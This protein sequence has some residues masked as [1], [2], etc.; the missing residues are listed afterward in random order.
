MCNED[1]PLRAK[2]N[3]RSPFRENCLRS[4][5]VGRIRWRLEVTWLFTTG[6]MVVFHSHV[7]SG[8]YYWIMHGDDQL[9]RKRGEF[10]RSAEIK[11]GPACAWTTFFYE[12]GTIMKEL[13]SD[14]WPGPY[15][16][17]TNFI[18]HY[19]DIIAQ[20][21]Y[22]LIE[23]FS[24][25]SIRLQS[26]NI[27]YITLIPKKDCPVSANDYR[28]ISLL[29][30]SIKVITRLLENGLQKIILKLVHTNQYGF[31]SQGPFKTA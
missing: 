26:I 5:Y 16:F 4:Y 10:G 25:G 30:C 29:N 7:P 3:N 13:S 27:S 9:Q 23:D 31:L 28:P 12:V 21:L 15:V 2:R 11:F 20:D 1:C 18:K 8:R 24:K 14:K 22:A 6:I 17:N 19:W